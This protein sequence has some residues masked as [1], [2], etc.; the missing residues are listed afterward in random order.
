MLNKYSL[1]ERGE[2][3]KARES[4]WGGE[5]QVWQC[6]VIYMEQRASECPEAPPSLHI[7]HP[8]GQTLCWEGSQQLRRLSQ[9]YGESHHCL[10]TGW[11]LK[12]SDL[13]PGWILQQLVGHH[14]PPLL[15][16][17]QETPEVQHEQEGM[18]QPTANTQECWDRTHLSIICPL[19]CASWGSSRVQARSG[20]CLRPLASAG[21]DTKLLAP[22]SPGTAITAAEPCDSWGL[23]PKSGLLNV[24]IQT[25]SGL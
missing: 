5:D 4:N 10:N 19:P 6:L 16:H 11:C 22:T 25:P 24:G 12:Q 23:R 7:P 1:A 13:R 2:H 14:P 21:S 17:C 9:G 8:G 18:K 15:V 20:Q 3:K